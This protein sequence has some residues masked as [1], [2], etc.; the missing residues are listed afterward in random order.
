MI[1][2]IIMIVSVAMPILMV[3][4]VVITIITRVKKFT[5]TNLGMTPKQTMDLISNGLRDEVTTPKAITSLSSVYAP[6]IERDFPQVG[7]NGMDSLVR[8][9][10]VGALNAIEMKNTS[11]LRGLNCSEALIN[12]VQNIIT[13]LNSK[14]EDDRYDNIVIHK[15]GIA[16]YLNKS[17]EAIATFEISLQ[18][19]YSKTKNGK[20]ITDS[21][22]QS[23]YRVL[24]TYNQNRH[25]QSTDM[26]Y[27]STCPNCGAP[28]KVN[29]KNKKCDYCGSGFTEIA[30]R[31]WQ[32]SD[33][34]LI[35]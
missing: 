32:V 26:V 29:G 21:L 22:I 27:T 25:E 30:D 34:N 23:A 28:I 18:Y 15:S 33:F 14:N 10:L 13:D 9:G 24:I 20:I 31:V 5:K 16:S 17:E 1:P 12:K 8:N 2:S 3:A 7:F 11:A 19:N 35:K 4:L 6:K